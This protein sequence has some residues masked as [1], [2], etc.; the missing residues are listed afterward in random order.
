M[1]RVL[2]DRSFSCW[3]K[4]S[5]A[6]VEECVCVLGNVKCLSS[7]KM[8][9]LAP[10]CGVLSWLPWWGMDGPG[11]KTGFHHISQKITQVNP[12][13]NSSDNL[14]ASVIVTSQKSDFPLLKSHVAYFRLIHWAKLN[15]QNK[16]LPEIGAFYWSLVK[17]GFFKTLYVP[18][19]R[20]WNTCVSKFSEFV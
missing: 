5:S 7:R 12:S 1:S 2:F 17:M 9:S 18:F 19:Q 14:L 11:F 6:Q 16:T 3:C 20:S 13:A 10:P 8:H 15:V 4:L